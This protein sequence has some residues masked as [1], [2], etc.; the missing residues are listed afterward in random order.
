[1]SPLLKS[2]AVNLK[3][4]LNLEF[5]ICNSWN[6][7]NF[8][9]IIT[10]ALSTLTTFGQ[11]KKLKTVEVSDTIAF[12]SIDRPGD[13]YITLRSGQN[14]RFDKDGKLLNLY[15]KDPAPTTLDPRDGAHLFAFYRPTASFD[16]LNTSF[17]VVGAYK[18]DSAF[19]LEPWLA[20]T[21]GDHGLWVLDTQDWNLKKLNIPTSTVT[22]EVP[23]PTTITRHKSDFIA[24]RE[25]QGFVFLLHK[26]EG[27]HIFNAMGK[28]LR[29]I[30]TP[31]LTY[32]NFIGE[33]LYYLQGDKLK[34]F[35]LFTTDA[36][37]ITLPAQASVALLT[38]D[39]LFLI[40]ATSVTIYT[41]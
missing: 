38:D 17:D 16:L 12:A 5:G 11:T 15:R 35:D 4:I 3:S 41:P 20:C 28:H 27:I 23:L 36:R 39:R 9:L 37:E 26:K 14:Q 2:I 19:S 22:V 30:G 40:Q 31:G 6:S 10:I 25:Y 24:L 18:I 33:E 32:F 34:F 29:T 8:T 21:A 13:L 7:W 1:M